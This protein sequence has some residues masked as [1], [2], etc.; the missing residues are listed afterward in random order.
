MVEPPT[1]AVVVTGASTGIGR[2]TALALAGMGFHVFAGV[3]RTADGAALRASTAGHLTPLILDVTDPATIRAAVQQVTAAVGQHGIAGLV[4]NAGVGALWPIEEVPLDALRRLYDVNVFGQV[5][6]IQHFLPLLRRGAGRIINIGSVGDRLTLP[7]GGVLCSSKW[8]FASIT[9]ALRLELR[10]WG[11]HVVLIEPASIHSEAVDKVEADAERVLA[12][13]AARPDARYAAEFR[14]MSRRAIAQERGGSNPAVVAGAVM[15]ALTVSR[16]KTRYLVG[17]DSH[18][19]AFVARWL[20]D[21]MFDLLRIR[22]FGLPRA[23]GGR[24]P[25]TA[26]R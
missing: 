17:R 8:A 16:P 1:G 24:R 14:A 10:P 19:L 5:D 21:R 7:F 9:E 13:L 20:P 11:I 4:D 18:R 15:H 2:A 25:T 26:T 12:A 23:F 6:V 22:L 3:R